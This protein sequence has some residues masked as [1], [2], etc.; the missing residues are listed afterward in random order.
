MSGKLSEVRKKLEELTMKLEDYEWNYLK[1]DDTE[2]LPCKLYDLTFGE[3]IECLDDKKTI[4][5]A[6]RINGMLRA[7]WIIADV[8][9][10]LKVDINLYRRIAEEVWIDMSTLIYMLI[11]DLEDLEGEENE[12]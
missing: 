6:S 12:S 8:S 1:V 7:L 3:L 5:M 2:S 10:D 4:V 11:D 9:Y